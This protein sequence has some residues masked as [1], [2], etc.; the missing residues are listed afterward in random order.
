MKKH[1]GGDLSNRVDSGIAGLILFIAGYELVTK[2]NRPE[3]HCIGLFVDMRALDF[4]FFVWV[5]RT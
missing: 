3:V 5:K 1:Q 4:L 2:H